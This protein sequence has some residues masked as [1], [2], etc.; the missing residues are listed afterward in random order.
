MNNRY[1]NAPTIRRARTTDSAFTYDAAT[2]DS[3]GNFFIG[4]LERLD[5]KIHEP[6]AAVTWG[7]D[8]DLREDVGVGDELSSFTQSSF[9]SVGGINPAGLNWIGDESTSI[10][11]ATVD[12]NKVAQP[13]RLWGSNLSYTIVELERSMRLGRPIDAQK[14]AAINL[15]HQM[16]I[17]QMVYKG[18]SDTFSGAYGLINSPKVAAQ[19]AL[20]ATFTAS[21]ADVIQSAVNE[22]MTAVWKQSGYAVLPKKIL[23]PPAQYA[24]LTRV[25]SSAGTFSILQ[26]LKKNNVTTNAS[27]EEIEILPCKWLTGAGASGSDRM[28]IYTQDENYVRYPLV[29]LQRSQITPQDIWLRTTY[30]SLLGQVEFVYPETV[31][32]QDGI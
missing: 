20:S 4:E 22:A 12:I 17:D 13:L 19:T 29:P 11:A 31:G 23:L 6:L 9:G 1:G 8:I 30:W 2:M 24:Q 14:L 26:Y 10:P 3:V 16:D 27:G 21:T 7:R 18:D 28:V 32:Y 25:N 5:P 15:K